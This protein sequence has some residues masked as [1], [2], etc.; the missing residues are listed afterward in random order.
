MNIIAYN[1]NHLPDLKKIFLQERRRTFTWV[2][3]SKFKLIDFERETKGESI[4]TAVEND[5]IIGFISVWMPNNFIHHLYV[6]EKH[7]GN[8]VGTQLLN[9]VINKIGFPITLKCLENNT[10]AVHFYTKKGFKQ[11][12]RGLSGNGGYILFELTD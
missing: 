11:K 4:L 5:I 2:D 10:Q 7:Q 6:A 12:E 8:G 3:Q 1:E 9:A